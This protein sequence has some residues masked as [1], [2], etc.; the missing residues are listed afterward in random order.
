MTNFLKMSNPIDLELIIAETLQAVLSASPT[1]LIYLDRNQV[2]FNAVLESDKQDIGIYETIAPPMWVRI[3][4]AMYKSEALQIPVYLDHWF[5][6]RLG[7]ISLDK[8]VNASI[9]ANDYHYDLW[10]RILDA[11]ASKE[12]YFSFFKLV[13]R[14]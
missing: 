11:S 3:S 4:R 14:S 6:T 13:L 7:Y 5:E 8:F 10:Q 12:N 2:W 1:P 9:N